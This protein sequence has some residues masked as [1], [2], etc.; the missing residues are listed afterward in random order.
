MRE[1]SIR[2]RPAEPPALPQARPRTGQ[3]PAAWRDLLPAPH[4]PRTADPALGA[5]A[6]RERGGPAGQSSVA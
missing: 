1:A 5:Y 2:L 4:Q 3:L 6:M